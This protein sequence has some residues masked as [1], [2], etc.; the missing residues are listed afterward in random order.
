MLAVAAVAAVTMAFTLVAFGPAGVGAGDDVQALPAEIVQPKLTSQG[1]EFALKTDK[2]AY[3]AGETP[4]LE[5][6]RQEPDRQTGRNRRVAQHHGLFAAGHA[7]PHA[8]HAQ[9]DLDPRVQTDAAAGRDQDRH[10]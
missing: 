8:G 10:A 2:P 4:T 9:A 1:C 7:L 6:D 5:L 3:Q